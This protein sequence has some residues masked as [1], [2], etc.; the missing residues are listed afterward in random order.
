MAKQDLK[1]TLKRCSEILEKPGFSPEDEEVILSSIDQY[2]KNCLQTNERGKYVSELVDR[3]E[4]LLLIKKYKLIYRQV[5]KEE[6]TYF[7][8]TGLLSK[9]NQTLYSLT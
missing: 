5:V 7:D 1:Q 2:H 8:S 4:E 3:L 9:I 6:T